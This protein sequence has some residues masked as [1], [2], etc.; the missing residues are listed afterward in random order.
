MKTEKLV[1]GCWFWLF[2]VLLLYT[3]VFARRF[4]LERLLELFTC[5]MD[6]CNMDHPVVICQV[7]FLV[8]VLSI[9]HFHQARSLVSDLD[10][11]LDPKFAIHSSKIAS[12]GSRAKLTWIVHNNFLWR[13]N[14]WYSQA[15]HSLVARYSLIATGRV[16]DLEPNQ[17]FVNTSSKKPNENILCIRQ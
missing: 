17:L 1:D 6:V 7:V 11:N 15:L 3:L 9:S 2:S 10:W 12:E 5:I 8:A 16:S 13:A 4:W 14:Q